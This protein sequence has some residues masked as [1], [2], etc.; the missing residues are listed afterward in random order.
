MV[1]VSGWVGGKQ[2]YFYTTLA[3]K[4]DRE[5]TLRRQTACRIR[6]LA[7]YMKRSICV[8]IPNHML[9]RSV[10]DSQN[11]W[12][13]IWECSTNSI[14]LTHFFTW[15]SSTV[16]THNTPSWPVQV[17]CV[18]LMWEQFSFRHRNSS[19]CCGSSR[20]YMIFTVYAQILR[21]LNGKWVLVKRSS[22]SLHLYTLY[23]IYN[24][25]GMDGNDYSYSLWN[26][27]IK[28]TQ[29]ENLYDA[30]RNESGN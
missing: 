14:P 22:L 23:L 7:E 15:S 18:V 9:F 21:R 6:Q 20:L 10:G 25:Y 30:L 16:T 2:N 12:M 24:R 26:L 17:F 4:L 28:K 29:L 13:N 27:C 8:G 1:I 5:Q 19:Y 3:L 11:E